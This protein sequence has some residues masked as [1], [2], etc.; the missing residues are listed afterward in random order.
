MCY[1]K[2]AKDYLKT[3]YIS[4]QETLFFVEKK[5]VKLLLTDQRK[6]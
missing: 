4:S 1:R 6:M 3:V 5:N 2:D